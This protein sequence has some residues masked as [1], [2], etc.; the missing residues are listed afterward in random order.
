MTTYIQGGH[1]NP[2][3]LHHSIW[4]RDTDTFLQKEGTHIHTHL[5]VAQLLNQADLHYTLGFS[6]LTYLCLY[7]TVC[8]R[9]EQR[10]ERLVWILGTLKGNQTILSY[11]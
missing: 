5:C 2:L 4:Q 7:S 9:P 6:F 1:G 10:G 11:A 3:H 8:V